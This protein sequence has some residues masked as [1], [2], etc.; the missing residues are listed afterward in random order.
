MFL[1]RSQPAG[2]VVHGLRNVGQAGR[3]ASRSPRASPRCSARALRPLA[4]AALPGRGWG[5]L[6][7]PALSADRN[8]MSACQVS[9]ALQPCDQPQ[10]VEDLAVGMP[11]MVE[12]SARSDSPTP[13]SVCDWLRFTSA[14]ITATV[15]TD[16]DGSPQDSSSSTPRPSPPSTHTLA[17]RTRRRG[18][19]SPRPQLPSCP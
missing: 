5:P 13:V 11:V 14:V 10:D 15:A 17:G 4:V 19:A 1:F 3:G 12:Q 6:G 9:C 16:V 7:W 8:A 2:G 18:A